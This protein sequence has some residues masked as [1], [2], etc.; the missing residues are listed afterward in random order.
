[1]ATCVSVLKSLLLFLHQGEVSISPLSCH[2]L[3]ITPFIQMTFLFLCMTSYNL[4]I[5]LL[6]DCR[7]NHQLWYKVATATCHTMTNWMTWP[8]NW[9]A[10]I[11]IWWPCCSYEHR[12]K[13]LLL[14]PLSYHFLL[15]IILCSFPTWLYILDKGKQPA[16]TIIIGYHIS[17]VFGWAQL[18]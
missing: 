18:N 2:S 14:R 8:L 13:S 11:F 7:E 16:S 12:L 4:V 6:L 10:V 15:V 1:M 9:N 17:P 5:N 3:I